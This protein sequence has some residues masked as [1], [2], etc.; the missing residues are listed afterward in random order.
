MKGIN[1]N[2]Y[3]VRNA[4]AEMADNVAIRPNMTVDTPKLNGSIKGIEASGTV[5][6]EAVLT[7]AIANMVDGKIVPTMQQ[8]AS[9]QK[10]L[11]ERIA[12]KDTTINLDGRRVNQQLTRQQSRSGI[13]I[14]RS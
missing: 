12:D 10:Q 2:M 3:K 14:R 4:T 5:T 8:N 6:L 9:D 1:D 7:S 11:L 13:S